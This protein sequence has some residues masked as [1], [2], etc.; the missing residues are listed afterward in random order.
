MVINTP[1]DAHSQVDSYYLRRNALDFKVPYF[2][3]IA[4]A[5]AAVE[6]IELLRQREIGVRALQEY[7]SSSETASSRCSE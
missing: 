5:D 2:T 1:I 6:G 7:Q 4:G 3:T